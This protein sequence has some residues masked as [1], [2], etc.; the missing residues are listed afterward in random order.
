V[1]RQV[2]KDYR[3][4]DL[5]LTYR[6]E[7][8]DAYVISRVTAANIYGASDR[9]KGGLVIDVGAHLG[10]FSVLAASEG[11]NALAFE[12]E[13]GN[14]GLLLANT[15]ALPTVKIFNMGV[16][17][18]DRDGLNRWDAS[19]AIRKMDLHI[20]SKN[21]GCHSLYRTDWTPE[22][23]ARDHRIQQVDTITLKSIFAKYAVERCTLLK[24]DCEGAEAGILRDLLDPVLEMLDKVDALGVEFHSNKDLDWAIPCLER[25]FYATPVS[26]WEWNFRKRG[27]A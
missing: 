27:D 5:S 21:T 23:K 1:I 15:A 14:F 26:K 25:D 17:C 6:E 10:S 16:R 4:R 7:T 18:E 24:M 12:P 19:P 8:N 2:F 22:D 3:R 13:V 9:L 20:H 11:A